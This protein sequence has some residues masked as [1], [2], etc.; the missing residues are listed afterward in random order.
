MSRPPNNKKFPVKPPL[1]F[2]LIFATALAALTAGIAQTVTIELPAETAAY[3]PGKNAELAAAFCMNCHSADY[4][5]MQPPMPR[6][7]WE[8]TVKKM[9]DKYAAPLPADIQPLVD[10]L[11]AAYGKQ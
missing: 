8:A 10:Y 6:K 11:T 3:R 2:V 4:V 1:K 5:S 9:K 7:F